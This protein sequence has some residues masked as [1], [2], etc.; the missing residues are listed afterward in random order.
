MGGTLI[1][2]RIEGVGVETNVDI[3]LASNSTSIC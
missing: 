3:L 1:T 2:V